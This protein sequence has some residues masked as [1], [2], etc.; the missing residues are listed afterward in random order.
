MILMNMK[1]ID[2]LFGN[3][4]VDIV[5]NVPFDDK[6]CDFLNEFSCALRKDEEARVYGDI[7]TFA[8]WIRKAGVQ[9]LR[10][11][12]NE[13]VKRLGRG[14]VFHIAPSNIPI[15][16]IY[17]FVFGMLSGN[18][19][20]IKVSSKGFRV[21]NIIC[22]ILKKL[23]EKKSFEWVEKQ[24]LF[25]CYERT[26]KEATDYFS[27]ICDVRIIW[28]GDR[29]IRKVRESLLPPR[30]IDI[31]FADRYSFAALSI[32]QVTE[33][34]DAEL[35]S[36]AHS[37][38]NDTYLM[39]QNAC[40]SPQFIFWVGDAGK[41]ENAEKRFWKA[42]YEYAVRYNPEDVKVSSKYTLL[43]ESAARDP[44][45]KVYKYGNILYVIGLKKKENNIIHYKGKYGMFFSFRVNGIEDIGV[46]IDSNKIQTCAVYGI[47]SEKIKECIQKQKI[48]GIDRIVPIGEAL[49]IDIFWDGYDVIGNLSRCI[50]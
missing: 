50:I 2:Y 41:K 14:L 34:S 29:T 31:T 23:T 33:A 21:V 46:Y 3:K 37:F 15:N 18:S 4:N 44:I 27:E 17:S 26:N 49:S 20:I 38:Y 5:P 12:R 39:D 16:F 22:R 28:G 8:F 35:V 1:G 42:V 32:E 7:Q 9:K 47:D 25:I 10:Q 43:C 48:K 6:I 13:N 24:N 30:S 40:S 19:N 11:N 36:L 45:S